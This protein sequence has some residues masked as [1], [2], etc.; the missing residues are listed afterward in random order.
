MHQYIVIVSHS[1]GGSGVLNV[2]LARFALKTWL[3][4]ICCWDFFGT[5]LMDKLLG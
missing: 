4:L 5:V 1:I 3:G 2:R